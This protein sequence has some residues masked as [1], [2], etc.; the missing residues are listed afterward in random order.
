MACDE[1][2]DAVALL[3][4]TVAGLAETITN[5][6]ETA[7]GLIVERDEAIAAL[8]EASVVEDPCAASSYSYDLPFH[9]GAVFIVLA[10]S[11]A[12][13]LLVVAG[14]YWKPLRMSPLAIALGKTM[15]TGIVL[16]CA[17]IHMLLPA[18]EALTSEC[19]PTA[20][21]TDYEAY[22]YL[23]ALL[24]ALLLQSIDTL[25]MRLPNSAK[26]ISSD[27]PCTEVDCPSERLS[28]AVS[29][30]PPGSAHAHAHEVSLLATMSAEFGFTIHSLFV[31]LAVGIVSD[32]ELKA[33]LV[34]LCFHQFFEGVALGARLID[35]ASNLT[36][37]AIILLTAIFAI[38][39]P[40]GIGTGVGVMSAEGLNVNG[41]AF[42]LTAGTFDA[43]C[44]GLLLQIGFSM[45]INDF[46]ADLASVAPPKGG[47]KYTTAKVTAMFVALWAGAGVMAFIGKY[48]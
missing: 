20:F 10:V 46:P 43:I 5:L 27:V 38:S 21:N 29:V 3:N 8:A 9:I 2:V 35:K 13:V 15:G 42:L 6:T 41:V 40:I 22:G 34:A 45:L 36:T 30:A 28:E 47:D 33:L 1:C 18:N 24:T 23:F 16:A 17:L 31:G 48:L 4:E 39:A 14:K 44:A 12:G 25:I 11:A 19:A 37:P 26:P 7:A 32:D